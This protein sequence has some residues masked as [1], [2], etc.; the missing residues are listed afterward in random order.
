L[1]EHVHFIVKI[2][3]SGEPR[4]IEDKYVRQF[5]QK[6]P[7]KDLLVKRKGMS[8]DKGTEHRPTGPN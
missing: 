2:Y 7:W 8:H 6:N 3:E 5:V 1:Q 4:Q